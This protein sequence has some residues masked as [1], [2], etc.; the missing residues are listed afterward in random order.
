MIS[1]L[2]ISFTITVL[3]LTFKLYSKH[4][5]IAFKTLLS[6]PLL[7]KV[8]NLSSFSESKLIFTPLRP[9]FAKASTLS[10]SKI[11][12][13]VIYI[14][15]IPGILFILPIS[16]TIPGLTKGS[17]PVILIFFIPR[18]A[19]S[20]TIL[21]ISSSVSLFSFFKKILSFSSMQYTHL[22]L[23]LSVTDTLK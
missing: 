1:S 17:P 12:L 10:Y 14:S 16:S 19:L 7:V 4:L 21:Y 3:I 6:S 9:F 20:F 8:L 15:S 2:F 13:V 11:P 22:K 23:Q 18:L 5:S